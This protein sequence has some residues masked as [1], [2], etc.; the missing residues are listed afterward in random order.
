MR[1][2]EAFTDI[3]LL[4]LFKQGD[5]KAYE[6]IYNRYWSLLYIACCKILKDE[7]EAKDIV[8]EVFISFLDKGQLEIKVSL[9]VYLYSSVRYKVLDR[10]KH[11]QVKDNYLISLS[12]YTEAA[13]NI[14]DRQLLEKEF[15]RQME[16]AIR[17]LPEK[18][19]II[20]D[21]SRNQDLSHKEIAR[22]LDI[23]DK[24]VKK[25]INNALKILKV[26]LAD[27]VVMIL[28]FYGGF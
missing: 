11:R 12:D 6:E 21:L 3:N 18:M 8:Q 9:S 1:P 14:T 7:D 19:R 2:F 22:M 26:K 24:T 15:I 10:I 4:E 16:D 13:D 28:W 20:F 23:S 27:V 5:L 17:L 25:Q